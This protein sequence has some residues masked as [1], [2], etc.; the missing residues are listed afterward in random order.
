MS[1]EVLNLLES[2]DRNTFVTGRAGTGKSWSLRGFVEKTKKRV[3][4]C[5]PTGKSAINVGGQ[6]IHSM[7]RIPGSHLDDEEIFEAAK[8]QSDVVKRADAIIIDEISMCRADLLQTVHNIM[9]L[10]RRR[11]D[12][13]FGGCQMI[14]FGDMLQLPPIIQQDEADY[15]YSKYKTP[16][17]FSANCLEEGSLDVVELMTVFRQT[18]SEFIEILNGVR[19]GQITEFGLQK[20]NSRVNSQFGQPDGFITITPYNKKSTSINE[21]KLKKLPGKETV[22]NAVIHGEFSASQ[23]PAD[24]VLR[25]K[26]GAQVMFIKNAARTQEEIIRDDPPK[27]V[28]GSM[29]VVEDC[30]SNEVLV[31]MLDG[32]N[33]GDVVSVKKMDWEI[34]KH[35]MVEDTIQK[36]VAGSFSQIPL[37]LGYAGS[38]HKSQG[39]SLDRMILDLDRGAFDFGQTYVALSRC[40]SFGNLVLTSPV[41][42]RDIKV[43]KRVLD[44]LAAIRASGQLREINNALVAKPV[45]ETD[46]LKVFRDSNAAG[47]EFSEQEDTRMRQLL[48]DPAISAEQIREAVSLI[49]D[50]ISAGCLSK[51]EPKKRKTKSNPVDSPINE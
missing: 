36:N 10:A 4:V 28:N 18:E 7:F 25:L 37:K 22:Y 21:D 20:L 41:A 2:S 38:I 31:K 23:E 32:H 39:A 17:F 15:Y 44:Y 45:I 26:K 5:A 12:L 11:P 34:I 8:R 14:F 9:R 46:P 40:R 16:Y 35:E 30:L 51:P 33:A 42:R 29:G 27:W 50:R 24:K 49:Y 19:N 43:D 1:D 6:T 3:A 47:K 48:C 13:P